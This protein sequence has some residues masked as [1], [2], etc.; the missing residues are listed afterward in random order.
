MNRKET[1]TINGQKF[2][3]QSVSPIWYFDTYDRFGG[4]ASKRNTAKYMDALFKGVVVEPLE[5]SKKG[6]E[7]FDEMGDI[8]TS[9]ALYVY[10]EKFLRSTTGQ[11]GSDPAGE[12]A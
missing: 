5:V 8:A 2:T 9:Q 4:G 1:I 7:Y 11:S 3:L 10:I 12:E 6:M